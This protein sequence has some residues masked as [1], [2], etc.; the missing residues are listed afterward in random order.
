MKIKTK[1]AVILCLVLCTG[2][3]YAA[4]PQ[5]AAFKS[6]DCLA[7]HSDASMVNGKAVKPDA[8]QHSIHGSMFSCVD[9]HE[10]VKSLS[11]DSNLAKPKCSKCHEVEQQQFDNSLHGKAVAGGNKKAPTCVACHGNIHE[12]LPSSDANSKVAH[13]NVP[14]TCGT[15][16]ST[17][18]SST[19]GARP[20]LNYHES[21]HGKL[22]ASGNEKAAVCSDCHSAHDVRAAGDPQSMT[23]KENVPQTCAKCHSGEQKQ[24]AASVHG[25]AVA[26]GNLHAPNCTDCHGIHTIKN[27][28]D[29]NSAVS[30]QNQ[31]KETCAQCHE[32]VRMSTEF[33]VPGGRAS[34]Y[35]ASYHGMASEGGSKSSAACSSCHTAHNILPASDT[36]SSINPNNLPKTCGQCHPGAN[37]NFANGKMHLDPTEVKAADM[38]TKINAW[39]RITYL[40]L[41][42]GTIG[43]MFI[44][45]LIIWLHKMSE[46]RKGHVHH[47]SGPRVVV[48]MT[49]LQRIQHAFLFTSFFTLVLTG[50]A[51]KYPDS[52]LAKAF[53]TELV[54]SYIHRFAGALMIVVSTY[55]VFYCLFTAEGRKL[56]LDMIPELKDATDIVDVFA[57]NL[58][59]SNKRPQFKRFNY[60]EKM[61]YLALVWGTF[62]MAATGLMIWFKVL[63]GGM[64][65]RWWIDVATTIHFY[66]AILATLAILVWHFYMIIF[67]PDTYPMNWAWL[68]GKMSVEHYREEHGLDT[69]TLSKVATGEVVH[70]EKETVGR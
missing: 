66:E 43:F 36:A 63:F 49:K 6:E 59:L 8:F 26:A 38:G 57:Y 4:G 52:L 65:P 16:H 11:H 31:A 1:F 32:N 48:R 33:S 28:K 27:V 7:C 68:D 24:F 19:N 21:V 30:A 56:A 58:G 14:Q 51:L 55:H 45:N 25:K 17:A 13:K 41:I 18:V 22:V 62:V 20:A 44:H 15:C 54:R 29:P 61:E 70:G 67:D 39:V 40:G 64:V 53:I 46:R 10:D 5:K 37:A 2:L 42:F 47:A 35:L 69:E 34:T 3:A 12:I 50:F 9:C 60:A 23:F